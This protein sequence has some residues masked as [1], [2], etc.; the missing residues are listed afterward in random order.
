MLQGDFSSEKAQASHIG[1]TVLTASKLT[2]DDYSDEGKQ[3][4]RTNTPG[5][6]VDYSNSHGLCY[7]VFHVRYDLV[8][9][10]DVDELNERTA[11]KHSGE[12]R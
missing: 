4:R 10:Y 12:Y 2:A 8:A 7:G 6:I 3:K 9:W 11:F 5:V 1:K